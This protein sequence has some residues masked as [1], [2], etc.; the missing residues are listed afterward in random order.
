MF[1]SS[2]AAVS[3]VPHMQVV[4]RLRLGFPCSV[5]GQFPATPFFG[6]VIW[7]ASSLVDVHQLLEAALYIIS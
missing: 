4:A 3:G 2:S 5:L 1:A 7:F 6:S